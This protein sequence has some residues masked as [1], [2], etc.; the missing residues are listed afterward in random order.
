MS[1][2]RWP[3]RRR[4]S[5]GSRY[6]SWAAARCCPL[7][8]TTCA[9]C[10][11]PA[12]ARPCRPAGLRCWSSL[13][14]ASTPRTGTPCSD[15]ALAWSSA[16]RLALRVEPGLEEVVQLLPADLLGEGDEVGGGDVAAPV[17][18][19]PGPKQGG[20]RPVAAPCR[21]CR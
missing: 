1:A 12:P 20:E 2:R 21:S 19:R 14:S 9:G 5:A 10:A 18:R 6:G 16:G 13:R 17:L 3:T 15:P 11:G 8:C 7:P 4:P